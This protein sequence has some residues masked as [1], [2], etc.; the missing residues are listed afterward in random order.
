MAIF[1]LGNS[2]EIIRCICYD[3]LVAALYFH[4]IRRLTE[5]DPLIEDSIPLQDPSVGTW[6]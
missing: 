1:K 6:Q 5:P 4:K 2:R 3:E